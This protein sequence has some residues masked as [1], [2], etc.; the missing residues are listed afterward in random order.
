MRDAYAATRPLDVAVVRCG[1]GAMRSPIHCCEFRFY[2]ELNDFLAPPHR[3]AAFRHCFDGHPSVKDRIE[4]LGVPHT[5]VELI[6]VDG[7]PVDF[8][9]RLRGGERVAVFPMFECFDLGRLLR[10]RPEPLREVRFVLDVHLGRLAAFLRLLGFDCIYRND[11]D[12]RALIAIATRQRRILL[13]RDRGLLKDGRITHGAFLHA[14]D[15]ILQVREVL[16]RFQLDRGLRPFSRCLVC[17]GELQ[18]VSAGDVAGRVPDASRRRF[19]RFSRCR[20]CGRVYWPGSHIDRLRTRFAA[21][22][23]DL[24]PSADPLGG[25]VARRGPLG[26]YAHR[27]RDAGDHSRRRE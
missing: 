8:A 3:R 11:L 20:R 9:H 23:V 7:A 27:R 18:R 24:E 14:T 1:N 6:L 15:P 4:A 2:E 26:R 10:L 12:D 16:D 13:S 17:N 25:S 21:I 19:D 22:G 5:E